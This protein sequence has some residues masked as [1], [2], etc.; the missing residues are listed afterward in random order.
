MLTQKTPGVCD[1]HVRWLLISE[2]YGTLVNKF[3]SLSLSCL[4][5]VEENNTMFPSIITFPTLLVA[6]CT[7]LAQI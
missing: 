6:F 4:K 5:K 2:L 3:Q 1:L 7:L